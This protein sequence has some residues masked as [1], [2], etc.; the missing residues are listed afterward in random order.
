[1]NTKNGL[2]VD[3][4]AK[5]IADKEAEIES[6]LDGFAGLTPT[7]KDR[8]NKRLEAI[9]EEMDALK[10]DLRNLT[11]PWDEL[12]EDLAARQAALKRTTA[13]LNQEGHFCQKAEALKTVVDKIVC[14]LRRVGKRATLDHIDVIPAEG[15]AVRPLTFPGPLLMESCLRAFAWGC[16]A[17]GVPDTPGPPAG[18]CCLP[19]VHRSASGP[20]RGSTGG[21][22]VL[23]EHLLRLGQIIDLDDRQ[24]AGTHPPGGVERAIG[25]VDVQVLGGQLLANVPK[26]PSVTR[27]LHQQHVS[28][29]KIDAD[30]LQDLLGGI[31]V[32][33]HKPH[34]TPFARIH[35][36]QRPKTHLLLVQR[37]KHRR[38]PPRLVDQRHRQLLGHLHLAIPFWS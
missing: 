25:V 4:A 20:T 1:M 35:D 8:V 38:K 21:R 10:G 16:L 24:R 5:Q 12:R 31:D 34:C 11:I 3:W 30:L 17:C 28:R 6:I 32:V 36:R 23:A 37:P 2:K 7:M 26:C 9:Q 18:G 15:A 27:Y 13:T 22:P 14:H 33:R 29:V 19:R